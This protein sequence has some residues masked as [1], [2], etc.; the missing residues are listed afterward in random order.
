MPGRA[1][2]KG[3]LRGKFCELTPGERVLPQQPQTLSLHFVIKSR[4]RVFLGQWSTLPL[5]E[6][7]MAG[8][9]AFARPEQSQLRDRGRAALR[10]CRPTV[11]QGVRPPT[12]R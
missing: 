6:R 1:E 5:R 11:L 9:R 7:P 3:K 2:E 8:A 4:A 10:R 12:P